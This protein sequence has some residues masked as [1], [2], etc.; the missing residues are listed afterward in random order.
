MEN[1]KDLFK[2][3]KCCIIIPTFNNEKTIRA[4]IDDV[5]N[6]CDDVFVVCDGCTDSTPQI[7]G[8][9]KNVRQLGYKKNRGKGYALQLGFAEAVKSGFDYA[10]TVDSDGQHYASDLPVFLNELQQADNILLIG[11]RRLQQ[12][13]VPTKSTFGNKFSSFWYRVETGIRL[14]DTQS[15]YRLY[16]IAR[17]NEMR[18]FTNR[19]EFEIEVIV[20]AAWAGIDVKC[21]PVDVF[22][23]KREERVSHFRPFKDFTRISILNTILVFFAFLYFR[24]RMIV[25]S[26]QKKSV[27]Q[28]IREDILC[29]DKPISSIAVA[30][31]FGVFM[32]IFPIWG[33]QLVVGFFVAHLLHINKWIFFVAAN[34][35]LPPMIPFILYFSY[36]MGGLLLG[37]NCTSDV[38]WSLDTLTE[39]FK[40]LFC[41][42]GDAG[43]EMLKESFVQYLV[44]AVALSIVAGFVSGIISYLGLILFRKFKHQ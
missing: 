8:E 28:I 34:I 19:F 6:Y 29:A 25:R 11:S 17:L 22:Y 5:S 32:G 3:L 12:E 42:N 23:P 43:L 31:G 30:I 26:F 40:I 36:A 4:V 1:Y 44:G 38:A 14:A 2:Q 27:R 39:N 33:Y 9:C 24:P 7:V 10:I 13:N 21:V 18:F 15:G 35:S 16:P 41:Q 37:G 20:R